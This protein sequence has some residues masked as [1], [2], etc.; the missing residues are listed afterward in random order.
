[1]NKRLDLHNRLTS[2]QGLSAYFQAPPKNTLKY[3]CIIY[4]FKEYKDLKANN[5]T[6]LTHEKYELQFISTKSTDPIVE[7]LRKFEYC[8]FERVY[9]ADGL[10]H[11]IFTITL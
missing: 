1:M 3:P 6:F 4:F 5:D 11:F 10:Y 2:I 7:L 9:V 8:S